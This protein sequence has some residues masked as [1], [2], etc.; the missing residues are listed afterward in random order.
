MVHLIF[1]PAPFGNLDDC[2]HRSTSPIPLRRLALLQMPPSIQTLRWA[3][4][5]IMSVDSPAALA[6]RY[7]AIRQP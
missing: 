3:I 6:A 2:L 1:V 4:A 5:G 7:Y